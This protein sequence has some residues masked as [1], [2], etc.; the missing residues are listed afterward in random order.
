[1]AKTKHENKPHKR[2]VGLQS[3]I[4]P[5]LYDSPHII[6]QKNLETVEYSRLFYHSHTLIALFLGICILQ[7][8]IWYSKDW[9]LYDIQALAAK[10]CIL[11]ILLFS[12]F[13]MPDTIV[14]RPHPFV[15]RMV[16]AANLIYAA[17]LVYLSFLPLDHARKTIKIFDSRLGD[18]LPEKSYADDWRIFTPENPISMFNNFRDALFDV[19]VIN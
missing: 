11:L 10:A 4:Q 17:F 8:L 13:Y 7:V 16:L 3:I 2:E 1:M 12:S 18:P 9:D 15:W 19:H 14:T 6:A 5:K